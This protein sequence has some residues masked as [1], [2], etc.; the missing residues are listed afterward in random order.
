MTAASVRSGIAQSVTDGA[1]RLV[2]RKFK[3]LGI[4]GKFLAAELFAHSF[5]AVGKLVTDSPPESDILKD[6]T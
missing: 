5:C 1:S 2:S 4:D 6:L 3:T